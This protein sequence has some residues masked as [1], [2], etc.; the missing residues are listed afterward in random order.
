MFN[1][2]TKRLH[3]AWRKPL[4]VYELGEAEIKFHQQEIAEIRSFL[5]TQ[6]GQRLMHALEREVLMKNAMAVR[7]SEPAKCHYLSGFALGFDACYST[8]KGFLKPIS[9]GEAKSE[10]PS[11]GARLRL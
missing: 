3:K 4:E 10:P 2:L 9:S 1:T 11:L 6:V 7:Q 8:L 5:R